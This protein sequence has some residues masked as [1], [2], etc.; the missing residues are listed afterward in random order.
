MAGRRPR[1]IFAT[2]N[3]FAPVYRQITLAALAHPQRITLADAML[4][5]RDVE[6]AFDDYLAHDNHGRGIV[7]LGH[8]QGAIILTRLLATRTDVRTISLSSAM[9]AD[10]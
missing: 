2:L 5:Y 4:A 6:R 8:S 10:M 7:L 3:L 9:V 1:C